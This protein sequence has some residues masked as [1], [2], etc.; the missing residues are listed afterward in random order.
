[1]TVF[2]SVFFLICDKMK[3]PKLY[4]YIKPS[5][6]DVCS[7]S[8]WGNECKVLFCSAMLMSSLSV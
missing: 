5:D 8:V 2:D 1:M 4:F 7:S 6:D 3:A